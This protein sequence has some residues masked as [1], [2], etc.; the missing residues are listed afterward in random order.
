[1]HKTIERKGREGG[2]ERIH[3]CIDRQYLQLDRI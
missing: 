2:R 1:M 3:R